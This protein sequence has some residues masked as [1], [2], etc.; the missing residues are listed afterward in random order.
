M[1]VGFQRQPDLQI[2]EDPAAYRD[3][4][5]DPIK[6]S[7]KLSGEPVK[8]TGKMGFL[9]AIFRRLE[10]GNLRRLCP[11]LTTSLW[12]LVQSE[13]VHFPSRV[14]AQVSRLLDQSTYPIPFWQNF[15]FVR[16]SVK[17]AHFFPTVISLQQD[18]R[19]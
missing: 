1:P 8:E 6:Q 14:P 17:M 15:G 2:A 3:L 11:E 16:K 13:R 18:S 19:Q 12:P 10:C 4:I 9:L 5:G 7:A